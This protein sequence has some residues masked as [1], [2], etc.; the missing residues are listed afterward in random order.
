[1]DGKTQDTQANPGC[2]FKPTPGWGWASPSP[3]IYRPGGLGHPQ[4]PWPGFLGASWGG[5]QA[6]LHQP[7]C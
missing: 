1:M 5:S 6:P 7:T 4:P 2:G 3:G